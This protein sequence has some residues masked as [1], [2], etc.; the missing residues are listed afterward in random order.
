M[1]KK[2]SL[3]FFQGSR[4]FF[5]D[6]VLI[7]DIFWSDL[8][9]EQNTG[10]PPHYS[11]EMSHPVSILPSI[12]SIIY[13]YTADQELVR[14]NC[15]GEVEINGDTEDVQCT[16]CSQDRTWEGGWGSSQQD[17]SP[18]AGITDPV[19]ASTLSWIILHKISQIIQNKS[20]EGGT[21]NLNCG[22]VFYNPS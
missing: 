3:I 21:K 4:V 17:D 12:T 14:D 8:C 11:R 20:S 10:L 18:A 16:M 6:L 9:I 15:S 5:V 22:K 19:L 1:R 2:T 7:F 13:S